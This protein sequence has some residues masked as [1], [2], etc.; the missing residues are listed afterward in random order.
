MVIRSLPLAKCKEYSWNY[1]YLN[2]RLS[3]LTRLIIIQLV[4]NAFWFVVSCPNAIIACGQ[5]S[6]DM[7]TDFLQLLH[8]FQLRNTEKHRRFLHTS[9]PSWNSWSGISLFFFFLQTTVPSQSCAA[10]VLLQLAPDCF[11]LCFQFL[12]EPECYLCDLL[13]WKSICC[14][15]SNKLLLIFSVV[16]S[17]HMD[18]SSMHFSLCFCTGGEGMQSYC[19]TQFFCLTAWRQRRMQHGLKPGV[20]I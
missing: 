20:T 5:M 13:N 10:S 18:Y 8:S 19:R 9:G 2:H 4:E 16:G 15:W 12:L 14:Q 3:N 6:S 11:T 1:C 7:C 17:L